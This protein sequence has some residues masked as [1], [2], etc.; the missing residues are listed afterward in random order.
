MKAATSQKWDSCVSHG[1]DIAEIIPKIGFTICA[2]LEFK[3]ATICRRMQG[4]AYGILIESG[5]TM[6]P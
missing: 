1:L 5:F 3:Y 4:S 6:S 2:G